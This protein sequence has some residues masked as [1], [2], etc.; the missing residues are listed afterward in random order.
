[1]EIT[2]GDL[3]PIPDATSQTTS[4]IALLA[5][6]VRGNCGDPMMLGNVA[7]AVVAHNDGTAP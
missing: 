5:Q 1:M 2:S 7:W 3:S 4:C 6:R